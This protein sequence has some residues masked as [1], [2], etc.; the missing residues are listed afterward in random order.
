M[1]VD[2]PAF[3]GLVPRDQLDL[4]IGRP[5]GRQE[6]QHLMT[7]QIRMQG[8]RDTHFSP[9]SGPRISAAS[10]SQNCSTKQAL[11][12]GAMKHQEILYAL[13]VKKNLVRVLVP[14]P[15][16]SESRSRLRRGN[17][18]GRARGFQLTWLNSSS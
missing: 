6:G 4:G 1:L 14:F 2:L 8:R 15:N 13:A 10:S 18:G 17:T 7:E 9:K 5:F 3:L 11:E 12:L 16:L